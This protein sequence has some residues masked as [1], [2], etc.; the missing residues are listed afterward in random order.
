MAKTMNN[1][2]NV[3]KHFLVGVVNT[4][5]YIQNMISIRPILSK[6]PYELWKNLTPNIS[7]F[8]PFECS[9]FMLN[10]KQ[11]LNKFDF[12]AQKCIMLGYSECLKGHRVYNIETQM[13]EELMHVKLYVKL[14]SEKSKIIERFAD[15]EITYP[16]SE[17]TTSE[18]K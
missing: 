8:H 7:Y 17:G 5:C 11:N 3:A 6:T 16:G 2:T 1:E 9:Y 12:K 15:L 14:D 13:V 18:A 10:T 4:A